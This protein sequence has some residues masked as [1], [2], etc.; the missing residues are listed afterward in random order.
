[1]L[2][3]KPRHASSFSLECTDFKNVIFEKIH[4][5]PS[6]VAEVAEVKRSFSRLPRPN[7][8]YHLVLTGFDLE[9][10]SFWVTRSFD[11]SNLGNLRGGPVNFFKNYVLKSVNQAEKNELEL[12][13]VVKIFT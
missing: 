13:L 11:L 8:G 3:R 4:C 1:M 7:F 12:G 5:A 6:E 2:T 10:S 9:F